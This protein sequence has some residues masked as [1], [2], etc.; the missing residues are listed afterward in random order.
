M[1]LSRNQ[2]QVTSTGAQLF[3]GS[4]KGLFVYL[5]C[6]SSGAF[7]SILLVLYIL[8]TSKAIKSGDLQ[9]NIVGIKFLAKIIVYCY[10]QGDGLHR[11]DIVYSTLFIY[12]SMYVGHSQ[13][14]YHISGFHLSLLTILQSFYRLV[15]Q[16]INTYIQ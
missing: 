9:V 2:P 12:M 1:D 6:F 3:S 15:S 10:N 14:L 16:I 7:W 8:A 11:D 13:K 5:E 4:N